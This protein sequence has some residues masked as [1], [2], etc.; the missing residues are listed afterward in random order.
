[1]GEVEVRAKRETWWEDMK[2]EMEARIRALS[3]K[4]IMERYAISAHNKV[5]YLVRA[6][7]S[8]FTH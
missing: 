1:M 2:M 7:C 6:L 3:W 8:S 5:H 4:D